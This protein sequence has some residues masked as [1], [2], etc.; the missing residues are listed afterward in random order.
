MTGSRGPAWLRTTDRSSL[1]G[2]W[3]MTQVGGVWWADGLFTAR[4]PTPLAEALPGGAR[5]MPE[6][7]SAGGRWVTLRGQRVGAAA[8][9]IA[10]DAD[11]DVICR[12]VLDISRVNAE[13]SD[14]LGMTVTWPGDAE[15]I[16][17]RTATA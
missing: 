6:S 1:A 8:W 15:W 17:H 4:H 9:V 3:A 10:L 14:I 7:L 12:W 16:A 13:L 11:G 5:T 2:Q